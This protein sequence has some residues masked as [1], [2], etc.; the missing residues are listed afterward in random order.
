MSSSGKWSLLLNV[1]LLAKCPLASSV[2]T[3]TQDPTWVVSA[4]LWGIALAVAMAV[5]TPQWAT[6]L[7]MDMAASDHLTTE[8]IGHLTSID[9]LLMV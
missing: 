8:D 2:R 3:S 1:Q 9:Q 7:G 4:P 6:A 5:P